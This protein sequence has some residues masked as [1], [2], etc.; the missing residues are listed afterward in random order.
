MMSFAQ[1]VVQARTAAVDLIFQGI[2]NA[3]SAQ[4]DLLQ[5]QNVC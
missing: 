5:Q 2:E 3:Y 4:N 1:G